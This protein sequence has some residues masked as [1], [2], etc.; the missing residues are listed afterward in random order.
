MNKIKLIIIIKN[1]DQ[2][3]MCYTNNIN[4]SHFPEI[5]IEKK[6]SYES[7]IQEYLDENFKIKD[8]PHYDHIA[9]IQKNILLYNVYFENLNLD[10]LLTNDNTL[11]H[12]HWLSINEML[13]N[14]YIKQSVHKYINYITNYDSTSSKHIASLNEY[15]EEIDNII[16]NFQCSDPK[17]LIAFRGEPSDYKETALTPSLFRNDYIEFEKVSYDLS[18]DYKLNSIND[19]YVDKATNLQHYMEMSRMLD[20]TF[21]C[22]TTLFFACNDANTINI[23]NL[24]DA[25]VYIFSFPEY[26]SPH[27]TFI[28]ELYED[29]LQD[30]KGIAYEKNFRVFS[31]NISNPRIKAQNGGF[32]FFP[33]KKFYPINKIYYKKIIIDKKSKKRL[34]NDLNTFFSINFSTLFPETDKISTTMKK[35]MLTERRYSNHKKINIENEIDKR[36]DNFVYEI[37]HDSELLDE[38][39]ISRI[40]RK[41]EQ[42]LKSYIEHNLKNDPELL[43]EKNILKIILK[44]E[45]DFKSYIECDLKNHNLEETKAKLEA[46]IKNR[47]SLV[48]LKYKY[49]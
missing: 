2:F 33:G 9:T 12:Y 34:L 3:L 23:E 18:V 45:Q 40:I 47:F 37:E 13:D 30:N 25:I 36:I 38:K 11:N 1:N 8:T 28:Q 4:K 15:L 20:I 22:L 49:Y 41:E 27:S 48:K 14:P 42:D 5:A 19:N 17:N 43:D 39:N 21:N 35:R 46:K 31:E 32:I 16:T 24:N 7:K 44:D 29:A 26:Y 6:D 10:N